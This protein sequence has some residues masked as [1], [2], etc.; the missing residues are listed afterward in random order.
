MQKFLSLALVIIFF[1]NAIASTEEDLKIAQTL[2]DN[3]I[4]VNQSQDPSTYRLD[5]SITRVELLGI[6]LKI[7]NMSTS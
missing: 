4:I 7:K 1:S 3:A 2:A 5:D 6:A